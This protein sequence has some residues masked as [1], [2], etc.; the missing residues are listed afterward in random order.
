MSNNQS[1][2]KLFPEFLTLFSLIEQEVKN[3]SP[4]QLDYTSSEWGWADWSIR[5]Q[6]SHM[7][8]LIPR[9][10]LIRW[11]DTLFSNN[12][13]GFTN[14]DSIAN[15][16][17]DRRLNDEIYWEISEILEIL[18]QS[19]NLTISALKKFS[20]DFFKMSNSIPRDPNE[21][22]KI[23]AEAHPSG[24]TLSSDY[25]TSTINLE[26]TFR[27]I[28]FEEIT[29]LYNIQRLKKAQGIPTISVI[30]FIG[31]WALD[32]WDRSEPNS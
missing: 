22:W 3:L 31:Y 24:V 14:L 23:M 19:I 4:E 2:I 11:G 7:A 15:S 1:G 8:S 17:Y 13:H 26:A 18:N 16:T 29:H 10:L 5:N 20:P 27:H 21:Q 28:L 6:L 25:K 12:E 30:P 9:W 32:S